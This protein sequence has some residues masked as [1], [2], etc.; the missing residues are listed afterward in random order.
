ME[1][2]QPR[3]LTKKSQALALDE[4]QMIDMNLHLIKNAEENDSLPDI[5]E[6]VTPSKLKPKGS[7][8]K[9]NRRT[10]IDGSRRSN[11]SK[12]RLGFSS[13]EELLNQGRTRSSEDFSDSRRKSGDV[14]AVRSFEE[15]IMKV[16]ELSKLEEFVKF[17]D[18]KSESAR[19]VEPKAHGSS[20][21]LDQRDICR[22]KN[23]LDSKIRLPPIKRTES[24][25]MA[26]DIKGLGVQ[27]ATEQKLPISIQRVDMRR[28]ERHDYIVKEIDLRMNDLNEVIEQEIRKE[29]ENIV[30]NI[31]MIKENVEQIML[32][33]KEKPSVNMNDKLIMRMQEIIKQLNDS[34]LKKIDSF[35]DF[36]R[37]LEKHRSERFK[38]ILK[39]AYKEMHDNMYIMPYDIQKFFE[40]KIQHLNEIT[41]NNYHC[42]TELEKKLKLQMEEEMRLWFQVLKCHEAV[43]KAIVEEDSIQ[44]PIRAVSEEI[45]RGPTKQDILKK[46][47]KAD[48]DFR[49]LKRVAKKLKYL[50]SNPTLEVF[51]NYFEEIRNA[52]TALLNAGLIGLEGLKLDQRAIQDLSTMHCIDEE[53]LQKM[54]SAAIQGF[55][56]TLESNLKSFSYSTGIFDSYFDR[57]EEL[58][59]LYGQQL[60]LLVTKN[61]KQTVQMNNVMNLLIDTLR[62]DISEDNLNK[63]MQQIQS[64]LSSIDALIQSHL[65][66]ETALVDK[67]VQ[68]SLSNVDILIDELDRF[69]TQFVPPPDS[70]PRKMKKRASWM[71]VAELQ[72]NDHLFSREFLNCRFLMQGI[73]NW[74]FGVWHALI[75]TRD[76][77]KQIIAVILDNWANAEKQKLKKRS[78]LKVTINNVRIHNIREDFFKVRLVEL[79]M[80]EE[81][82]Q[83]HELAVLEKLDYSSLLKHGMKEIFDN[84]LQTQYN[85]AIDEIM[86][87]YTSIKKERHAVGLM[88]KLNTLYSLVCLE[89]KTRHDY[90]KNEYFTT[91]NDVRNSHIKFMKSVR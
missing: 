75:I 50:E 86:T 76:T 59:A 5:K 6:A 16:T 90:F 2:F 19:L 28:K 83:Q 36:V 44:E 46:L 47:Q 84:F 64:T 79:K 72:T 20:L 55:L 25:D 58:R 89:M 11:R 35:C 18:E 88:N 10:S 14:K 91:L 68:L 38:L 60:F 70:D 3:R 52:A 26:W 39:N 74:Q 81:R 78:E 80:H 62:Q 56:D 87:E 65:K 43:K 12:D 4:F 37:K 7:K 54:W 71:D 40:K 42:Y 24:Q 31:Q 77:S 41:M 82:F 30:S 57:L 61:D 8:S 13:A 67:F 33:I 53:E 85:A 48:E 66:D 29:A 69:I 9:W 49:R 73:D 23:C 15:T 22:K 51:E 45:A 32:S 1:A 34:R 63:T 21:S 27:Q 17:E